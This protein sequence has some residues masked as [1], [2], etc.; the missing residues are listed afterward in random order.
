MAL[1]SVTLGDLKLPQNH[2]IFHILCP[3]SY[4]RSKWR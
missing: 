3:F 1:F 4:L 2:P